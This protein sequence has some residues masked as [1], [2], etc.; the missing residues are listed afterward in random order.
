MSRIELT[1]VT[2]EYDLLTVA[3]YNLKRKIITGLGR[4]LRSTVRSKL[5][6]I[7]D[8]SLTVE[9]GTRVG[10]IGP[11]GAG[12]STLLRVMAGTL[13]PT[14]G[15]VVLEGKVFSLL[16]GAGASLDFGLSGYENVVLM[17]LLLG[18]TPQ[19][20]R[21][22]ADEIADFSGLGDRLANPVSSY[23]SGMQARLRFS[24][25]TT[26]RPQVLIMDE[27]VATADA[28]FAAK[29]A[30]RLRVFHDQ[31]EIVV[32]SSHGTTIANTSDI[33]V[34]LDQGRIRMMGEPHSTV[35]AYLDWAAEQ[36][37]AAVSGGSS[38]QGTKPS[39]SGET[40]RAT[41]E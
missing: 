12:K 6:A 22:K 31:A 9:P 4:Q 17:G 16:G 21:A 20:M 29:A 15:R 26:L 37:D 35:K 28:A 27:G 19:A 11:N 1:N 41:D 5:V 2:V 36:T 8:L 33:V 25:L 23:S 14:R 13:P 24:V 34:W 3:D 7:D 10:L 30:E 40:D 39:P 38:V 18:E 32:M